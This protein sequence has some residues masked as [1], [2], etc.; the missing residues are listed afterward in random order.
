MLKGLLMRGLNQAMRFTGL[1]GGLVRQDPDPPVVRAPS[2]PLVDQIFFARSFNGGLAQMDGVTSP[3]RQHVWVYSCIN[4]IAQ[5]I[6]AVPL[7]FYAGTKK[8]KRLVDTGPLVKVFETPNPLMSGS[9]LIE[10]SMIFLGI[11]GEAFYILDRSNPR[12]VPKEIWTFHPSR[13]EHVPDPHSGLTRGWLY[14]KGSKQIPLEPHEVVF[15][16]YFNPYNDYRGF[17]PIEAAQLSIDQDWY[18]GQYNRNFFVNSAQTSAVLESKENLMQ[19]E[20]D[21]LLAQWNDRHQGVDKAHQV[22]LLEG[23]ITYKQTGIS[24]RD[25]DFLEGRKYS[26]D[27]IFAVYKV[28]KG[29]AGIEDDTGSYAKDKVRRKLFWETTLEPKMV[30]LEYVLWSQLCRLITGPEVWPEF[31]RKSIPALQEDRG[32]LL[33]QAKTLWGMGY[34]AD[35]VNEYLDLGLPE[36]DGGGI[37]YL[38]FNLVPSGSVVVPPEPTAAAPAPPEKTSLSPARGGA[39]QLPSPARRDAQSYWLNFNK[40][41]TAM[42]EKFH[43]KIKR[44]FFEQR[45][46]QL[47]LLADKLGGK[48]IQREM[49]DDLLFNLEEANLKLQKAAWAFWLN[50]GQEA[51][52]SIYAELGLAPSDF[53]IQDSP[54]IEV[55][56]TKLIKVVEIND[57]TRKSLRETLA[58]GLSHLESVSQL[59]DRV[60]TVF[61]TYEKPA[62]GTVT[63]SLTIARTETGQA[64]GAARDVAMDQLKVEKIEWGTAGDGEVRDTHVVNAAI[65]P[66]KRGE[67]FPNGCRY[68]CD[69][70]GAASEV[71][72]CRCVGIP[73]LE[74]N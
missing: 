2:F 28:P 20:F 42:E 17:S 72:N 43:S 36:I 52:Q 45:K 19:E 26:R 60:R 6:A 5:N 59:Q 56:K 71:I 63:R 73:V 8:N 39:F 27:E 51:G 44:Y 37:G 58:E 21:R 68:P 34:P 64:M 12:E 70:Q 57:I 24:Q 1:G 54:A 74:K 4:A 9:Q 46:V 18:A 15:F 11:T 61:N 49:A 23:G 47:Q 13:F 55:L 66:I 38:P 10:A 31:D 53:I 35:V 22:A 30:L 29:E 33:E 69:P 41:R 67:T 48:A 40:L 32:L 25:M 14:R 7:N 16:R 50:A 3:Y 65:G 62:T